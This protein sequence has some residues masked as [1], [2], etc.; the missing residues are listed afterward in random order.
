MIEVMCRTNLDDVGREDWPKKLP[1]L[2]REGDLIESGT[3]WNTSNVKNVRVV[4]SVCRITFIPIKPFGQSG[5]APVEWIPQIELHLK[6]NS[7]FLH[8][9]HFQDWYSWIRGNLST[10]T[11]RQRVDRYREEIKESE[12][13]ERERNLNFKM[14]LY[15]ACSVKPFPLL[16][17]YENGNKEVVGSP[18]KLPLG[19]S[20]KIL[21]PEY[22]ETT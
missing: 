5:N 8:I 4:L 15:E 2:P 17:E 3:V 14:S 9:S 18:G 7:G 1:A 13:K 19:E 11:Y 20:F 16:I 21:R 12:E 22:K 6:A 10:E